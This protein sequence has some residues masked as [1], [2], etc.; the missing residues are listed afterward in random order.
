MKKISYILCGLLLASCS[1]FLEEYSQDKSQVTGYEDLDELLIGDGYLTPGYFIDQGTYNYPTPTE[2]NFWFINFMTD[3]LQENVDEYDPDWFGVRSTMFGY[4]TWQQ[5]V[6]RDL[7]GRNAHDDSEMWTLA[8]ER[9]NTCNMILAAIDQQPAADEEAMRERNRVKGEAAFLRGVYYYFLVN[10]YGKPY[11]PSTAETTPGVPL[12]LTEYV[13][14]VEFARA[15]VAAVYRQI[16]NDLDM[17]ET[18]L[19]AY[20]DNKSPYRAGLRAVY[21]FRSRVALYMQDWETAKAYAQKAIDLN[22]TLLDLATVSPDAFPFSREC[23]ELVFS[24]GGNMTTAAILLGD[25]YTTYKLSDELCALYSQDDLRRGCYFTYD[26]SEDN[27]PTL[28]KV[29]NTFAGMLGRPAEMSDCFV[30]RNS[31]AYLNL[32]EA[33]A[34]LNDEG[35]AKTTLTRFL[36]NRMATVDFSATGDD[37]ISFIRDERARE[38]CLEGQRWFDL[39]RYTVCERLPWSKTI[40]HVFSLYGGKWGEWT[41]TYHYRLEP[42]DAAYTLDIPEEV[43]QQQPSIGSN[44][45]PARPVITSEDITDEDYEDDWY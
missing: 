43:R 14:D 11:A 7:H 1:D 22:A 20:P 31:E 34:C 26:D 23:P 21:I 28:R 9:V 25:Y 4:H 16:V 40:E 27:L 37:L 42:N 35:T 45:R 12:K 39:R 41:S 29:D 33:A 24:M 30:L 32:A 18:C 10:L 2:T 3:E 8:Y 17:A 44:P 38:F 5:L 36:A 15:S 6:G 13:E 19:Q